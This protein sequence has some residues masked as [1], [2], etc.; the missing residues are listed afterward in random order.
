M[1]QQRK[2][3]FLQRLIEEFFKK[4]EQMV[5]GRIVPDSSE[6]EALMNE[7]FGFFSENLQVEKN[8]RLED[9]TEKISD[10]DLLEQYAKLLMTE[11]DL[12]ENK[13]KEGLLKPLSIIEYLENTDKTFSWER[14]VLKEDILHRLD[15]S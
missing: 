4:L 13:D 3:D 14:T 6:K 12:S 9:L 1:L 7:C 5:N 2:K 10:N 11:Y 15:R 8:D